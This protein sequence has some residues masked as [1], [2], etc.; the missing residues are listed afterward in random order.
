MQCRLDLRP[1][2]Q[3]FST[4]VRATIHLTNLWSKWSNQI[5]LGNI[6]CLAGPLPEA[7]SVSLTGAVQVR[8][9]RNVEFQ[10]DEDFRSML[11]P[12]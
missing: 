7:C 9:G 3:T 12:V 10:S 5:A 2:N 1:A 11:I 8:G 6:D 4:C